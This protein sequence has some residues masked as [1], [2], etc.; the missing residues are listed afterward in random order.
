M[1]KKPSTDALNFIRSRDGELESLMLAACL[2]ALGIPFSERPA[3]SVS[4]DTEPVVNWLFD[5]SSLDLEGE[6]LLFGT[7]NGRILCADEGGRSDCGEPIEAVWQSGSMALGSEA[8]RRRTGEVWLTLRPES[9]GCVDIKLLTE[10]R[11]DLPAKRVSAALTG[12]A[13]A[14]FAHWS[15]ATSRRPKVCRVKLRT[16]AYSYLKMELK[17]ASASS[18]AVVLGA[19]I[20]VRDVGA[21]R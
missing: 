12:F 6:K 14:Q 2:T 3:F 18:T 7:A 20:A 8:K 9:S 16:G 13:H 11:A 4:G 21:M 19:T 1:Q 15:F 5:E 17:S 10:N